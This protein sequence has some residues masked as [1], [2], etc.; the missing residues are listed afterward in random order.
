MRIRTNQSVQ[1][2]VARV[3]NVAQVNTQGLGLDLIF[4]VPMFYG[5]LFPSGLKVTTHVS[6]KIGEGKRSRLQNPSNIGGEQI[7]AMRTVQWSFRIV[8]ASE[9]L[10]NLNAIF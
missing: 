6:W 5:A 7:P 3:L 4:G 10:V 1:R 9:F 2:N 8:L